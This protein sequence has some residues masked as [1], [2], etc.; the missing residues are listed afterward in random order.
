MLNVSEYIYQFVEDN[1]NIDSFSELHA[2]GF[3]YGFL[4]HLDTTQ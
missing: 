1:G 4:R 3:V 2:Y